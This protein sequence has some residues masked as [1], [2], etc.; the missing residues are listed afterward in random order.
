[1]VFPWRFHTERRCQK[2]PYCSMEI[3][4]EFHAGELISMQLPCRLVD[5]HTVP[6]C[7]SL[8]P[9]RLHNIQSMAIVQYDNHSM[10]I[11]SFWILTECNLLMCSLPSWVWLCIA[12]CLLTLLLLC[13]YYWAPVSF[14]ILLLYLSFNTLLWQWSKL[15]H[16][17]LAKCRY[18]VYCHSEVGVAEFKSYSILGQ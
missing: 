7:T 4:M 16:M 18:D 3:A 14:N 12:P 2:G 9:V 6:I 13:L 5:F 10:E 17:Q 8:W 1:M 15:S 11:L